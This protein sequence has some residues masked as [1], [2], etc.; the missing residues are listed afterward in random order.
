MVPNETQEYV[1]CIFI[2][3]LG[4]EVARSRQQINGSEID[5]DIQTLKSGIY[6]VLIHTQDKSYVTKFVK[7]E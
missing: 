4:Q 1:Q 2:N 7:A 5:C 6:Q 3:A